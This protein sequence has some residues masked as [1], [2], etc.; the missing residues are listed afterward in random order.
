MVDSKAFYQFTIF[1]VVLM[2]KMLDYKSL[3]IY[4]KLKTQSSYH[5][6]EKAE[7]PICCSSAFKLTIR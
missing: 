3:K 6:L 5:S 2:P 4:Q 7:T 1:S